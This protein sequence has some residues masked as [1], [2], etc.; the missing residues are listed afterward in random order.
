MIPNASYSYRDL[1]SEKLKHHEKENGTIYR[2]KND[3]GSILYIFGLYKNELLYSCFST[4]RKA[5]N[6]RRSY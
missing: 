2:S 5:V 1:S 6:A 4:H 3:Q